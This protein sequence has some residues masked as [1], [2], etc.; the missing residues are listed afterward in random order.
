MFR[1]YRE[2]RGGYWVKNFYGVAWKKIDK[3]TYEWLTTRERNP[4][5]IRFECYEK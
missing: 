1:L 2:L 5:N 4:V 3:N